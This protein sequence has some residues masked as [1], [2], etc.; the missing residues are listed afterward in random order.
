MEPKEAHIKGRI[1]T[2]ELRSRQALMNASLSDGRHDPVLIEGTLGSLRSASFLDGTV[3]EVVGTE[4]VLRLDLSKDEVTD[5]QAG[6]HEI[7]A[8][9]A[10]AS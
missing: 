8:P 9:P 7:C 3:L 10:G 1:F 5:K 2:V 6:R 4:G